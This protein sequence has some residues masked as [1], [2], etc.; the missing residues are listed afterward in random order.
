MVKLLVANPLNRTKWFP[1]WTPV[2]A[3]NCRELTSASL[4]HI[5]RALFDIFLF[6]LLL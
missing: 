3:T 2:E 5:L 1:S 4:T 6:R